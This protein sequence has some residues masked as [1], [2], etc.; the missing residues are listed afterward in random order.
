MMRF[1]TGYPLDEG[2]LHD[3]LVLHERF[4][5][6]IP[7]DYEELLRRAAPAAAAAGAS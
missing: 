2:D 3:V 5:L 4:G 7:A 1:H 6:A